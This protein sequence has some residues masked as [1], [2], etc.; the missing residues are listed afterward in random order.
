MKVLL[1]SD[2]HANLP[3]L[4]AVLADAGSIDAVW[5][6][7]DLTGYGP[8]PNECISLT[9]T[10]PNLIC[11][12]GNHDTAVLSQID[13]N[14]F[15]DEARYTVLW[16]TDTLTPANHTRLSSYPA[17]EM[18][19]D[20]TLVHASPRHPVWEYILDAYTARI[21]FKYFDTDICLVGHTHLPGIFRQK[22]NYHIGFEIPQADKPIQMN[23][24]AIVN[25]G[26]VGQPR[27]YNPQASYAVLDP[28]MRVITFRRVAYDIHAVQSCMIEAGLPE[29]HIYRLSAGY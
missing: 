1:I 4:E 5:C 17:R 12:T 6:L 21:N 13:V 3:A 22:G 9:Q 15:N 28:D 19:D 16:T 23:G 7:G 8:H 24:R 11:L 18:K 14:D 10:L 26:S 29:R 25:P 27:D 20:Y 2:V